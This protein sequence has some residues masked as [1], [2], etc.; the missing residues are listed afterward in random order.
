MIAIIVGSEP[1]HTGPDIAIEEAEFFRALPAERLE[2]VKPLLTEKTFERQKV[3][4]FEGSPADRLWVVRR[5]EVRLY[6]S[7][8]SGQITTLDVL[9]PGEIFG[10]RQSGLPPFRVAD[11]VRDTDLLR[12]ARSDAQ[13]WIRL[14]PHLKMPEERLI[15]QRVL[16]THGQWLGLG[17]TG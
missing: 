6:K 13:V 1:V 9:G 10:A 14:S 16:K 12:L 11:L 8:P 5:G 15:L 7:S 3:L 2:R 17:D 4:Y